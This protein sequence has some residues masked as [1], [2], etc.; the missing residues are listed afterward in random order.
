MYEYFSTVKGRVPT[1]MQNVINE[2]KAFGQI[3]FAFDREKPGNRKDDLIILE[4]IEL[5]ESCTNYSKRIF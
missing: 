3:L 1:S 4:K 2:I 5:F